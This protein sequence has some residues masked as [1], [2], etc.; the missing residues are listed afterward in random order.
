MVIQDHRAFK[1]FKAYRVYMDR[2]DHKAQPEPME[3][4]DRMEQQDPPVLKVMQGH[5]D[6]QET[7]VLTELMA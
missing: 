7:M 2:P 3:A 6:Q 1:V 4:M 5:K